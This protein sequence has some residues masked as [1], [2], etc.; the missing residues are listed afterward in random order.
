[1]RHVKHLSITLSLAVFLLAG[2]VPVQ[3]TPPD[4]ANTP[5]PPAGHS[6]S[7]EPGQTV[8]LPQPRA[9]GTLTLEETLAQ[10]RSIRSFDDR[11]LTRAE[12]GQLLWAAQGITSPAGLRTSPSAGALYPLEV[13]VVTPDGVYR[14]LPTGH[15]LVRQVA[16][17][18]RSALATAALSQSSV[19]DAPTVIVIAAAYARTI[20]KYGQEHSPRYVHLEA[21]HA[22]Q[23]VLLQAVALGLGA[24][25]IGAFYDEQ[26]K[27]VLRLPADQQPLYLIPVGHSS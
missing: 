27:E 18:V 12:L 16:G 3:T 2:C 14:Y 21:G 8:T 6:I 15:Q 25:P 11:L 24:V 9:Q 22:A 7:A 5:A 10:R 26:V 23:N 4:V 19:S 17:D 13:Y 20:Q 1:M